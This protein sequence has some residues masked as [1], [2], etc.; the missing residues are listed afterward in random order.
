MLYVTYIDLVNDIRCNIYKIQENAKKGAFCGVIGV[1]RSGMLPAGIISQYL[2]VGLCSLNE[3]LE[4]QMDAFSNHGKR[5]L[6]L[7]NTEK[8]RILVVEDTCFDGY[9]LLETK[10]KLEQF[11]EVYEFVFMAVYLEGKCG[12][13]FP[14]LYLRDVRNN[15][16]FI[17]NIVLYEWNILHHHYQ[18]KVIYDLDGVIFVEPPD[19]R[20]TQSYV[21]YIKNPTPLFIP[22]TQVPITICTYRLRKYYDI[23]V[24]SLHNIGIDNPNIIMYNSE[25][26]E[27]R[28]VSP[29]EYKS[30]MYK[31]SEDKLLFVESDD[32]Q[33]RKIYEITGKPVYCT[34]TNKMYC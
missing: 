8:K 1:P 17:K 6:N 15:D 28:V 34:D 27:D 19:E 25:E 24:E 4:Y 33:A 31:N 22:S 20:D 14:D 23:T 13:Y 2:N 11:N 32:F 21:E 30:Y 16:G 9:S 5:L 3:F 29:Y 18:D 7:P 10:N 12:K 26:Y